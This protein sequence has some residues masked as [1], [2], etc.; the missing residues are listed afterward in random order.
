M[1]CRPPPTASREHGRASSAGAPGRPSCGRGE[2]P[3]RTAGPTLG[4]PP[5]A[6]FSRRTRAQ[7]VPA[8][9]HGTCTP[10]LCSLT[11]VVPVTDR[12]GSFQGNTSKLGKV[13]EPQEGVNNTLQ[14]R[15]Q[16]RF[17]VQSEAQRKAPT[18]FPYRRGHSRS[19][20]FPRF[21][22]VRLQARSGSSGSSWSLAGGHVRQRRN[23]Q[24][25]AH[26]CICSRTIRI[27]GCPQLSISTRTNVTK[28]KH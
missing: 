15:K 1:L 10:H 22:E 2:A 11:S 28:H 3:L 24:A 16:V 13:W 14:V 26:V 12:R 20:S 25:R 17:P 18:A 27:A 5:G 8:A 9:C 23:S 7:D 19:P 6:A 21:P 4:L